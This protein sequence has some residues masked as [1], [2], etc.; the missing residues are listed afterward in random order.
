MM[1]VEVK[2]REQLDKV[3]DDVGLFLTTPDRV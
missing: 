3:M 1:S 2:G